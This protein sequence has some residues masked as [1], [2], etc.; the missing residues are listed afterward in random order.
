MSNSDSLEHLRSILTGYSRSTSDYDLNQHLPGVDGGR[1]VEAGVLIPILCRKD[2]LSMVLTRRAEHLKHHAGQVS[3][4]GGRLEPEDINHRAAA[5][6]EAQ[7]EIGLDPALVDILG[8]CPVHE[9]ATGFRITPFV[10][11]LDGMAQLVRCEREVAEIFEIP[12]E[13][14]MNPEN[15][16]IEWRPWKGGRRYYRAIS[17]DGRHIWGATAGIL[18]GLARRYTDRCA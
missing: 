13:F 9:T 17:H 1:L 6:R 14:A 10:G 16:V 7:E 12:F 18:Y 2:Q 8:Q 4:P 5:L 11:V 3:F 15:F